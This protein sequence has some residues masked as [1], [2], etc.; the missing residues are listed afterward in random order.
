MK[1]YLCVFLAAGMILLA[2]CSSN[3]SASSAGS[4]A[5]PASS[6]ASPSSAK[7]EINLT[8]AAAASLTDVTKEIAAQYKKAA[9]NV[10][11]TFT[12]GSSGALQTQ[13]EQGAPVD[14]FMSAAKKQMDAL[15]QKKLIETSTRVNLLENKLVLITPKNSTLGIKSFEDLAKSNVKKIAVGDP[16][17]VPAG[18]YADQVFTSLKI[19]DQVKPKLNFGTD[20]RQVLTWVESGNSDCGIVY[21]TDAKTTANV[22]IVCEAPAGSC[23]K[24]IYPVA[25]VKSSKQSAASQDFIKFMESSEIATLF[26][27]FGFTTAK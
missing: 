7:P 10:T 3:T 23:D 26:T 21:S 27:N 22:T 1:K 13:I 5:P 14:I 16:K 17:S 2:G 9:P 4:S 20:V 25:V 11:L 12:Y 19:S 8:I 24:V 18:Q 6:S 15:D